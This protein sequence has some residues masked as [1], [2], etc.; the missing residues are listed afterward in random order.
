MLPILHRKKYRRGEVSGLQKVTGLMCR[1]R[2]KARL[3]LKQVAPR[4]RQGGEQNK[5]A[6]ALKNRS[7]SELC[8]GYQERRRQQREKDG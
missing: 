3:T 5:K 7:D 2:F 4:I 6:L 1:V 8:R